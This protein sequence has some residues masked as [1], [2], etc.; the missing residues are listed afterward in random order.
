[1][2]GCGCSEEGWEEITDILWFCKSDSWEI[3]SY[4]KKPGDSEEEQE[5]QE[6]RVW[7]T[8]EMGLR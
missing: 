5:W 7:L 2:T 1:L 4:I 8:N 6:R 3:G